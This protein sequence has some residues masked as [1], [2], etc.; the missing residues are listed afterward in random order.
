MRRFAMI[1]AT[2]VALLGIAGCGS[3]NSETRT[4]TLARGEF[5]SW[6]L[7]DGIIQAERSAP[8]Y[9]SI[10]QPSALLFIAPEGSRV[11]AGD[12]VAELDG[13]MLEQT[14]AGLERDY[15][16]A[17]AELDTLLH[18]DIPGELATAEQEL[19]T[20]RYE[21]QRQQRIV[22]NT[23]SLHAQELVSDSEL[24]SQRMLLANLNRQITF[25]EGRLENL[26]AIVHP[27]REAKAKAQL[28][29]AERQLNALRE[30]AQ[31]ARMTAPF[32]GM[33][34][35]L[36]VHID[37][38]FRT[39]RE[40]DTLYRNQKIMQIADMDS[41]LVQAQVPEAD[42]SRVQ[43]GSPVIVTPNAFP[44][45]RLAGRID[46]I[47]TAASTV[48]GKPA[49]QKFF[50][51]VIRLDE[52]D[53]RLRSGMSVSAQALVHRE[54]SALLI[55]R[56]MVAWEQETPWTLIHQR[57]DKMRKTLKLGPGNAS[58]FVVLDGASEGDVIQSPFD[59]AP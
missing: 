1:T 46:S 44:A 6:H 9:S 32:A 7:L 22:D 48:A 5:T 59:A 4:H 53:A 23:E 19:D 45:L 51:V 54:E 49:W 57:G 38:E 28:E 34:A 11:E 20:L 13:A 17:R 36:P 42:I 14:L 27:A 43:P 50:S 12:R 37:G 16:L 26:R 35:H 29:A 18:A 33:V 40:G 30:Q 25:K 15:A 39:V 47:A 41:L 24:E 3:R 2:M 21:A 55:P 52:T 31:G 8:I 10:S 58:H 56:A